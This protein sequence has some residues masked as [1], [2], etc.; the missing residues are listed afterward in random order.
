MIIHNRGWGAQIED[1]LFVDRITGHYRFSGLQT[2]LLAERPK[3]APQLPNPP[4]VKPSPAAYA[5]MGTGALAPIPLSRPR[6]CG[7][8]DYTGL[9]KARPVA[10]QPV[11]LSPPPAASTAMPVPRQ[12][13]RA[14]GAVLAK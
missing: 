2:P 9:L 4:V 5:A 14:T 13:S 12:A 8:P 6:P 10:C 11:A 3:A 1:A 7:G